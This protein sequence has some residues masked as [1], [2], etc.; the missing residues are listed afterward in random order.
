MDGEDTVHGF[1]SLL[2]V[3]PQVFGRINKD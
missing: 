1:L 3:T 2:V